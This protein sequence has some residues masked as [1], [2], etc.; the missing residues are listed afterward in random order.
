L[1]SKLHQNSINMNEFEGIIEIT[2]IENTGENTDQ[3]G[4]LTARFVRYPGC[5]QLSVWLPENG[6]QEGYGRYQI[7]ATETGDCIEQAPVNQKINGNV[8]MTWE[9][10]AWNPGI[11]HLDI[12]HPK[13]GKHSMYFNKL[14]E[15]EFVPVDKIVEMPTATAESPSL[16]TALLPQPVPKSTEDSMW[17]VYLDGFGNPI[18]NDDRSFHDLYK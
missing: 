16:A 1:L 10:L 14:K 7:V 15:G 3:I 13:G 12:V 5:Q 8:K 9:T 6:W 4:T 18:R 2:Q 11:Y 17:K